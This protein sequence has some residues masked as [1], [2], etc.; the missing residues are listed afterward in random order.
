MNTSRPARHPSSS[1][2]P[3]GRRTSPA[4]TISGKPRTIVGVLPP[5]ESAYPAGVYPSGDFD[6]WL[7]LVIPESSFLRDR[8]VMQLS[9][10]ARLRTGVTLERA[11][12]EL[13]A[14]ARGLA[15]EYPGTNTN[16]TLQAVPLIHI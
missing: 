14:F 4:I 11:N 12:T 16:R 10:I 7:P 9:A 1:R 2:M 8:V 6:I 13:A 5:L 3:S 15:I